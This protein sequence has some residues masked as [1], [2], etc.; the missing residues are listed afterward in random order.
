MGG[1]IIDSLLL[2]TANQSVYTEDKRK[3]ALL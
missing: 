2:D 3:L 1:K